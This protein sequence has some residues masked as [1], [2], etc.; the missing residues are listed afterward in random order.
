[1]IDTVTGARGEVGSLTMHHALPLF[2]PGP[3]DRIFREA[4]K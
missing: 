2:Q 1:M 4:A 3:V